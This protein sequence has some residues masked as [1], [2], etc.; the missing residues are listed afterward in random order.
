MSD[1]EP[2]NFEFDE[3]PER[4]IAPPP[5][6]RAFPSTQ[7]GLP[8]LPRPLPAIPTELLP[9]IRRPVASVASPLQPRPWP[10]SQRLLMGVLLATLAASGATVIALSIRAADGYLR[11]R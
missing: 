3:S 10:R 11:S 8:P 5:L 7:A 2:I 1:P 9:P 4:G 6:S